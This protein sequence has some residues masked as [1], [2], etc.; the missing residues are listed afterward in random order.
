[1]ERSGPL[2]SIKSVR[3]SLHR[4]VKF[5]KQIWK[6]ISMLLMEWRK[7]KSR[8]G[9]IKSAITSKLSFWEREEHKIN[10]WW[11]VYELGFLN[12]CDENDN[13]SGTERFHEI[14][15]NFLDFYR[16]VTDA[17]LRMQWDANK[18]GIRVN[19]VHK[20]LMINYTSTQHVCNICWD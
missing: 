7:S 8:M 6:W 9:N 16:Y 5:A 2:I 14:N 12:G 15:T 11:K 13:T 1:M 20:I 4:T 3:Y 19:E 10:L 17:Y 18:I